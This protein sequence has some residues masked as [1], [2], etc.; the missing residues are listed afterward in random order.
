MNTTKKLIYTLLISIIALLTVQGVFANNSLNATGATFYAL[1]PF[2]TVNGQVN[3]S[4]NEDLTF[5]ITLTPSTSAS[6][7]LFFDP[8]SSIEMIAD[9]A[10][11]T[12]V[13][14]FGGYCSADFSLQFDSNF[15]EAYPY[16]DVWV[17]HED[18]SVSSER[19]GDESHEWIYWWGS[20]GPGC[21]T[22]SCQ[23]G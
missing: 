19:Y 13:H 14:C 5:G 16:I 20:L 15:A 11:L 12:N 22:G 9:S 7:S 17:E 4:E 3:F 6:E 1:G 18:N 23:P 2:L 8:P 21:N 10:T